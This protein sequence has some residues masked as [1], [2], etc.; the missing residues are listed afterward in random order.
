MQAWRFTQRFAGVVLG[1]LGLI[2]TIW[3]HFVSGGFARMDVTDMV[4]KAVECLAL[5]AVL[6]FLANLTI[7][8][9]A[10]FRFDRRGEYRKAKKKK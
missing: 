5:Q 10:F 6:A 4:W 1:G 8:L 7:N 9:T 3:M 2:L